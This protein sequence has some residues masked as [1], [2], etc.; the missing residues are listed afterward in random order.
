MTGLSGEGQKFDGN[1]MYVR[2][3]T[4]GGSK[5]FSTGPTGVS[6]FVGDPLFGNPAA[7]PQGTR[8]ARPAR[9][10]PYNREFECH[11]NPIPDLSAPTGPGF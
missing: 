6:E 1:G 5:T 9:K 4:G 3:Q 11:R 8:P 7:E 10:P 2:F